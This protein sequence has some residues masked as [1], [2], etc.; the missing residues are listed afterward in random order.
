MQVIEW[1]GHYDNLKVLL[2]WQIIHHIKLTI[3]TIYKLN[4]HNLMDK[5]NFNNI[6]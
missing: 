1:C 4:W 6:K 5:Y 3:S 2:L